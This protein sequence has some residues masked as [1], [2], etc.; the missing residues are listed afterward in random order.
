[1][2]GTGLLMAF[3]LP[4]GSRG[5]R[6]LEAFG[7]GRHE[8]ADLHTWNSYV[9]GCAIL[10]HLAM[11]WRWLWQIAARKRSWSMVVGFGIGLGLLFFLIFQPISRRWS[12]DGS[13]EPPRRHQNQ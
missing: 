10:L 11:H 2:A 4:Q 5:G 1:M 7:L 9:F 8:W 3:R 13:Q 6:G 12:N